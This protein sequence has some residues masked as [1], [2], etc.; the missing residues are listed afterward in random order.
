MNAKKDIDRL[1]MAVKILPNILLGDNRASSSP[2]FF[3]K[4]KINAVLNM[5]PNIPHTF[6]HSEDIEYLR[7]PVYDSVGKRDVNKMY[8][9]FP[10]ITE[11][12][13]KNSVM[14]DKNILVHCALGRQRSCAAIAAYLMRFYKMTP[15]QAMDFILKRKPDAFHWGESVNFARSLNKWYY[16]LNP[17][18]SFPLISGSL[19]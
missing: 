1:A 5:T 17:R 15:V 14:E 18:G 16:K 7:I 8:Q 10:M 2:V 9:Y 13:Y 3:K 6:C 4:A 12:I 11:F 19:A